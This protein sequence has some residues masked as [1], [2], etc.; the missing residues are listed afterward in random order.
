VHPID[1]RQAMLLRV[2]DDAQG[3]REEQGCGDRE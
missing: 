1:V 2:R 3:Y